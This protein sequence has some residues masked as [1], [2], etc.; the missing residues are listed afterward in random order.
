M[1]SNFIFLPGKTYTGY[2]ALCAAINR[3]LDSGRAELIQP[4]FYQSVDRET[5][6]DLLVGDQG[7]Q[8]PLLD[9]RVSCLNQVTCIS[10]YPL[11]TNI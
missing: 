1:I 4:A 3:S 8:I 7:I 11:E 2:F 5:L 6:G 10:I 9:Q